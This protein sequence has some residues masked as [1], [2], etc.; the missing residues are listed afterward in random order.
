MRR[1]ANEP[2]MLIAL[3]ATLAVL[4]AAVPVAAG[5]PD[6]REAPWAPYIRVADSALAEGK[7]AAAERALHQA[8]LTALPGRG[9]EGLVEVGDAYRRAAES[10]AGT[11]RPSQAKAREYYLGALF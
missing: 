9:W 10:P 2:T 1:R 8:Y 5:S 7:I 3:T 11:R 6:T 4:L